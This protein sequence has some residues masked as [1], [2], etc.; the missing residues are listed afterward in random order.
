MRKIFT[1]PSV[2]FTIAILFFSATS[3][4]FR[5]FM[6]NF[7]ERDHIAIA[8]LMSQGNQVYSQIFTNHFPFP[9][10]FNLLFTPLWINLPFSRGLSVFRLTIT[11]L[12]LLSFLITFFLLKNNRLK[13]SFS[14]SIILVAIISPLFHGNLVLSET[15]T[16]IFINNLFWIVTPILFSL[17][18]STFTKITVVIIFSALAFW[19]QPLLLIIFPLPYLIS[20]KKDFLKIF[21]FQLICIV[22]PVLL[23]LHSGQFQSFFEEGIIFNLTTYS[24][25][26]P[27]KT[28]TIPMF[29][30]NIFDFLRNEWLMLSPFGGEVQLFQFLSHLAVLVILSLLLIKKKFKFLLIFIILFLATRVRDIKIVPGQ[31]FNFGIYPFILL[32][33]SS[34]FFLLNST[35]KKI[36][37]FAI[38]SVFLLFILSIHLCYPII[39][40]SLQE[41]YNYYVFFSTRQQTGEI[42]SKFSKPSDKILIYPQDIDLYYFSRRDP[43]DRFT[44]W[45]PWIEMT[46]NYKDERLKALS[47]N[48][49]ALI[50]LGD[51]GYKNDPNY[52]GKLFPNLTN[53]YSNLSIDGKKSNLWIKNE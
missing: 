10:Y 29:Q 9:Y 14:L 46:K 48:P 30:Q 11:L 12:Y 35:N 38:L 37:Y 19:T 34:V 36:R 23:F 4:L 53:N 22:I 25:Y 40:Q 13:I 17:E 7:D 45:F 15:F 51:L 8:Y 3:F 50:Y 28:G 32:S 39:K 16:A 41:G 2:L 44:Y 20:P 52:Y 1:F 21:F 26:F 27:E 5:L 31:L 47:Q 43:P 24:N 33:T 6:Q 49:P 18:K 42:I